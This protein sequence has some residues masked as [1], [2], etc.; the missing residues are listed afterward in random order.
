MKFKISS[1]TQQLM[2]I[3]MLMKNLQTKHN[4]LIVGALPK[5]ELQCRLFFRRVF[6]NQCTH[7][8]DVAVWLNLLLKPFPMVYQAR[9]IFLLFGPVNGGIFFH[10]IK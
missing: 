5:L 4:Y 10:Y 2:P 1:H 8:S 6:L 9:V 3:I 7:N